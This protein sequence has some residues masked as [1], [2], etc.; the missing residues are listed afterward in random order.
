MSIVQSTSPPAVAL[1]QERLRDLVGEWF[2]SDSRLVAHA[3]QP[4]RRSWSLQFPLEVEVGGQ[5]RR[6][7]AK[8]PVWEAAPTL[9]AA[10]AAGPQ[11]STRREFDVLVALA[12][13]VGNAGDGDF[14]AVE[15][16]AY[17]PELNAIVTE[18]LDARPLR[19]L[20]GIPADRRVAA[21]L[22]RTGRLLRLSH[23]EVGGLERTR[24]PD[25][26]SRLEG[27]R[28]EVDRLPDP[29]RPLTL[30]LEIVGRR[31][32]S[33][34][35]SEVNGAVLHN[36]LNLANVLVTPRGRVALLDP[37]PGSGIA[38]DDLAKLAAAVRTLPRRLL[39]GGLVPRRSLVTSWTRALLAGYRPADREATVVFRALAVLQRWVD[40]EPRVRG[41][42]PLCAAARRVLA[43]E[44]NE[45][46]GER[47]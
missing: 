7:V 3:P 23:E 6:L 31:A 22:A 5:R 10:L 28:S 9:E 32:V 1:V 37:N 34:A 12:R 39:S 43:A 44:L 30:G 42:G 18:M 35:G 25:L 13:A 14:A 15:P 46:L 36:D 20:L 19:E 27:L 40:V 16:I 17:V 33:L 8:I 41:L 38:V 26:G 47:W 4:V 45:A 24:F 21:L 2:G 11:P 29:P